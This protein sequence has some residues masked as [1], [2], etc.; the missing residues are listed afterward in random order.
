VEGFSTRRFLTAVAALFAVLVIGTAGYQ[1]ILGEGLVSSAYR[2][3]VTISLTGLDS[4]PRGAGGKIFT[5]FLLAA[6]VAIFLYVA[7]GIV[8]VIARGIL[9]GAWAERRRR[10]A[11]DSLSD[12]HIICGYGRVGRRVAE[13][14]R[15]TGAEYVV[16]DVNPEAVEAARVH[17]DL[18]L[19]GDGTREEDLEAAGLPRARGLVVSGDSDAD[20]VYIVLSARAA[21]P[22]LLIVARASTEDAAKTLQ[23]A[24]ADRVVQPYRAAGRQMANLVLKPQ[25][26]AFLDVVTGAGGVDFRFEEI[27][28]KPACGHC[29]KTIGDLRVRDRTGA[30]IVGVRRHD[31]TFDTTPGRD[32]L[33]QEDDVIIAVG[34][35]AELHALEEMFAIRGAIA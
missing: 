5:I 8:E 25:V 18:Y 21:R 4:A 19:V 26:T 9:T 31:G 33:L 30:M 34:T 6:G 20:N 1:A 29:G 7:G 17:G 2:T 12:H 11:I 32:A 22:D 24:G 16:L 28:V 13:E 15:E 3:V 35:D 27:V 23:R 14:F 10:K